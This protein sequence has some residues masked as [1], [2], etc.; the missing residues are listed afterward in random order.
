MHAR[1]VLS[2]QKFS[3]V[4]RHQ[5]GI[6]D[7]VTNAL[8]R[9]V[10]LLTALKTEIIGFDHLKELYEADEDFHSH[11]LKCQNRDPNGDFHI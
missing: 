2:L 5:A 1:W 9:W 11:W 6:Q 7:K 8:S 4:F 10:C 3:F